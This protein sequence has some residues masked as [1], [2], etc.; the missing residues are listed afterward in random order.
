MV[1]MAHGSGAASVGPHMRR[2][3][4]SLLAC[5]ALAGGIAAGLFG[6]TQN[7]LAQCA[8]TAA[9]N[10]VTC[11]NKTAADSTNTNA[12]TASSSDREQSFNAGGSVTAMV[13]SGATVTGFGLAITNNQ[14]GP[15]GAITATNNSTVTLTTLPG[16]AHGGTAAFNLN[17]SVGG[18]S[19]NYSGNGNVSDGGKG[20]VALNMVTSSG[21][22]TVGSAGTPVVPNYSGTSGLVISTASGA[23]NVFLDGGNVTVTNAG[24]AGVSLTATGSGTI[25][26]TIGNG[27]TRRSRRTPELPAA[28]PASRRV[29]RRGRSRSRG[30]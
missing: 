12:G 21:T 19:I 9:P 5:T 29:R 26:A 3:R 17:A 7:V 1:T 23:Q 20:A 6:T 18:G 27:N 10:T 22:V 11:A 25:G 13:N 2:C 8:V 28:A 30:T 4:A 14:A 16:G 24:G 15:S